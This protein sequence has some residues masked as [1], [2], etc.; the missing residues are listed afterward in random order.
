M[1]YYDPQDDGTRLY[2]D[3]QDVGTKGHIN[4]YIVTPSVH[5]FQVIDDPYVPIKKL[6]PHQLQHGPIKKGKGG[7]LKKW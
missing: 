2:Y 6:E 5:E 7:K 3:T 4:Y 1:M